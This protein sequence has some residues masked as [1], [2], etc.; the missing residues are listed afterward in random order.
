MAICTFKTPQAVLPWTRALIGVIQGCP[1]P[2][3]L[4]IT[5]MSSWRKAISVPYMHASLYVDDRASWTAGKDCA[6]V[7]DLHLVATRFRTFVSRIG[8]VNSIG[9][10]QTAASPKSLRAALDR[11]TP[12]STAPTTNKI[13]VLDQTYTFNAKGCADPG[14][15]TLTRAVARLGRIGALGRHAP[16][17]RHHVHA[18]V[19]PLLTWAAPFADPDRETSR[20]L[21][22]GYRRLG[23][24]DRIQVPHARS[25]AGHRPHQACALSRRALVGMLGASPT[26]P[27]VW[28]KEPT[29]PL[30]IDWIERW[31]KSVRRR[32]DAYGWEALPRQHH[33]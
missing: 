17:R 12:A 11:H 18:I 29:I 30:L 15:D 3:L 14:K 4:M 7:H 16:H 6:S 27:M 10:A 5:I 22:G 32:L 24:P 20:R 26:H 23:P 8:L 25:P 2:P 9:K 1:E 21:L 28:Q 33:D 19:I 31:S 13:K